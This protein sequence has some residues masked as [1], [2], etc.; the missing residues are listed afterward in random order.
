MTPK[1]GIRS[2]KRLKEEKEQTAPKKSI[3]KLVSKI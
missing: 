1:S 2:D 3:L